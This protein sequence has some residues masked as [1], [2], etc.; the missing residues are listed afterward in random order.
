MRTV[1]IVTAKRMLTVPMTVGVNTLRSRES[2][3][4]T[5]RLTSPE[6]S[7]RADRALGPPSMSAR[8]QNGIATPDGTAATWHPLPTIQSR[9]VCSAVAAPVASRDM[10]TT[11]EARAAVPPAACTMTSGSTITG[12][13]ASS[14]P[15]SARLRLVRRGGLSSG[16][17]SGFPVFE[18]AIKVQYRPQGRLE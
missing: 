6:T 18:P 14:A 17:K 8:A 1:I 7:T 2:R 12:G 15:W 10:N 11:H 4:A 3:M 16:S 5:A 9:A 13:S